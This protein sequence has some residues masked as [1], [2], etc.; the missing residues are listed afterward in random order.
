MQHLK[1]SQAVANKIGFNG[2]SLMLVLSYTD[3][4]YQ[5]DE[6]RSRKGKGKDKK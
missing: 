6:A 5:P 4:L 1:L 3:T 2:C